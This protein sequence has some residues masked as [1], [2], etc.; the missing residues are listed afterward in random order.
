MWNREELIWAAGLFEGE[1]CLSRHNNKYCNY[2]VLKV[3]MTDEDVVRKFHRIVKSGNVTGPII[4]EKTSK[5][6]ERKPQWEWRSASRKD[7]YALCVAFW[8]FMGIRRQAKMTEAILSIPP[9]YDPSKCKNGHKYTE[10]NTYWNKKNK[11]RMCR[12]CHNNNQRRYLKK[13]IL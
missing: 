12:I 11:Q 9:V 2:W 13:R 6:T 5:G 4:K 7:V 3:S 10:E 8:P 1:G